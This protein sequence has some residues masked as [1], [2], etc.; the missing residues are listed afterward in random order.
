MLHKKIGTNVALM[1]IIFKLVA[2]LPHAAAVH[3]V[4]AHVNQEEANRGKRAEEDFILLCKEVLMG[5]IPYIEGEAILKGEQ[6]ILAKK[7]YLSLS[8]WRQSPIFGQW[9]TYKERYQNLEKIFDD[10]FQPTPPKKYPPPISP[11]TEPVVI[12]HEG[13]Y[14]GVSLTPSLTWSPGLEWKQEIKGNN[15]FKDFVWQHKDR[16]S[17]R[18]KAII[19]GV[20]GLSAYLLSRFSQETEVFAS[21]PPTEPPCWG[22]CAAGKPDWEKP[23]LNMNEKMSVDEWNNQPSLKGWYIPPPINENPSIPAYG[24]DCCISISLVAATR[25]ILLRLN[26]P[27]RFPER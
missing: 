4:T 13:E 26:P 6:N 3:Q 11:P 20:A 14:N 16:K 10:T 19:A 1:M 17:W 23:L 24:R 8:W 25:A 12:P 27:Q 9:D 5:L 2:V 21:W 7:L 15:Q 22:A 18:H